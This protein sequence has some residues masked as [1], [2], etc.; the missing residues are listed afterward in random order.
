MDTPWTTIRSNSLDLPWTTINPSTI[1]TWT[2]LTASTPIIHNSFRIY[3]TS[4]TYNGNL[5]GK[6]GADA[7]CNANDP[8]KP[9]I[10]PGSFKALIGTNDRKQC[11]LNGANVSCG[12]ANSS[13]PALKP[14]TTYYQA[15]GIKTIATTSSTGIFV[16]SLQNNFVDTKIA[17][18][19]YWTGLFV[20]W[21]N[22]AGSHCENFT[23]SA[24]NRRANY[25]TTVF[26]FFNENTDPPYESPLIVSYSFCN[27]SFGILCVEQ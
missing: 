16:S 20:L 2:W 5:G 22:D 1:V 15:D 18:L 27:L 23:S 19:S 17:T 4:L 9:K 25:S 24:S 6:V 11:T 13:D 12:G 14:N 7:K 26:K 8:Y 3:V 10:N 21:N